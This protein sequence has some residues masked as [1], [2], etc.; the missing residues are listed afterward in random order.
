[1]IAF[2]ILGNLHLI[3]IIQQK[4]FTMGQIGTL[5]TG[6]GINTSIT[7]QSQ[8]ESDLMIGGVDTAMPLRG[9]KVVVG[10][11]TTI[12][13]QGS[14]PLM[15]AFAKFMMR[16][17]G[18]VVGLV[19]KIGT[20]RMR[21]PGSSIV[22]TNDGAT[23][24]IIYSYSQGG[25]GTPIEAVT[26]GVNALSNLTIDN[27]A[28]LMV[29]PTA[30][31]GSFDVVYADGTDQSMTA[32]EADSLFASKNDAQANGR[33]DAVVTSFDNRDRSIRSVKV[34]ATTAVTVLVIR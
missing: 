11:K 22:L 26:Q 18:T 8:L 9:L 30:N 3:H 33:L 2:P 20:G 29:T 5:V 27:F 19:I 32:L 21:S 34:N 7:G 13:I 24:P 15:S 12:D 16:S 17:A 23:T 28:A 4:K 31:I 10:G 1:M 14:Q 6:A 25:N